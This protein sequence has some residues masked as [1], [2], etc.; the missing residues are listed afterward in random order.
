[1]SLNKQKGAALV[2]TLIMIA[3]LTVMMVSMMFLSQSEGW[4]TMNYRLM[5]QARDGAEAAVYRAANFLVGDSGGLGAVQPGGFQ[6]AASPVITAFD[7]NG[8][9]SPVT[10]GGVPVGLATGQFITNA[11][12]LTDLGLMA[13]SQAAFDSINGA[14]GTLT[15]GTTNI[16]YGAYAEL[17]SI[18]D[19]GA[20]SL[21]CGGGGANVLERW[22]VTGEGQIAGVQGANV[23]VSTIIDR[24]VTSCS[25]VAAYATSNSCATNPSPL[26]FQGGGLT[27]SYDSSIAGCSSGNI[28]T[29]PGAGGCGLDDVAGNVGTNGNATLSNSTTVNGSVYSPRN[30]AVGGGNCSPPVSGGGTITGV[31]PTI[32]EAQVPNYPPPDLPTPLPVAGNQTIN[33]RASCLGAPLSCS[34]RTPGGALLPP[35]V[36]PTTGVVTAGN[37]GTNADRQFRLIPTCS[38][39]VIQCAGG[40]T[41]QDLTLQGAGNV[42]H[43]CG[44]TYNVNAIAM[45]ANAK[46]V[47]H[48]TADAVCTTTGP[49]Y[50]NV[51]GAGH[52]LGQPVI[53]FGSGTFSNPSMVAANFQ[54]LYSGDT[55]AC[56]NNPGSGQNACGSIN[57]AGGAASSA[58]VYAPLAD[59]TLTGN[60]TY[61]G[62]M[63]G[64]TVKT[65]GG[66]SISYDRSLASTALQ[67]GNPMFQAFTWKKF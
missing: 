41:F 37:P 44:G 43:L 15:A 10:V 17:L 13:G 4:S 45:G 3:V 52:N 5:S 2:L 39:A 56:G 22:K 66:A 46:I 7:N 53:D 30:G 21:L 67:P 29:T 61:Y 58:L 33:N 25:P 51:L 9:N 32:E 14:W 18:K 12:T 34:N 65:T 31:P 28:G 27:N 59:I 55:A 24:P 40:N 23:Q 16:N 35:Y 42:F 19:L 26:W 38:P 8:T 49:V 6:Y 1:M 62:A 20:S 36:D 57:M 47:I 64:Y 48:T 54:L 60:G 50:V 11:P 63:I